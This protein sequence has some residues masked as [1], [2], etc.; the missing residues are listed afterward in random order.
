MHEIACWPQQRDSAGERKWATRGSEDGSKHSSRAQFLQGCLASEQKRCAGLREQ[1][2]L[3][4]AQERAAQETEEQLLAALEELQKQRQ[5]LLEALRKGEGAASRSEAKQRELTAEI[6]LASQDSS[7]ISTQRSPILRVLSANGTGS[8]P[9]AVSRRELRVGRPV[10][11]PNR[12]NDCFWL[13]ALQCLRHAPGFT[14]AMS[15]ALPRSDDDTPENLVE[16]VALLFAK[17]EAA[18]QEGKLQEDC[19][20]L[21][22]LRSELMK[23]LP[24]SDSGKTLIQ[25][26]SGSQRQQDTHEFLQQ[27]LDHLG[28]AFP[29]SKEASPRGAPD[30]ERLE[31]VEKEL[32]EAARTSFSQNHLPNA[33]K[34]RAQENAQNLSYEYCMIQWSASTTRM[35]SRIIGNLFEGQHLAYI[36]CKHCGRFCPSSAEPFIM[37]EVKM[38]DVAD[39]SSWLSNF[40]GLFSSAGAAKPQKLSLVDLLQQQTASPAPEGYICPSSR[41]KQVDGSTRK[42]NFFR[43]PAILVVHVNRALADGSRCEAVL[44]FSKKLDLG[45]QGMVVHFGQALDRQL[46]PCSQQ[47][48]LFAVVF[49]RGPT[50]RSGHYFAYVCVEENWVCVDD[51][52]VVQPVGES[53]A[54]PWALEASEPPQ[55]G[56]RVAM[57]FYRRR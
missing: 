5:S 49:H 28:C 21:R 8:Q 54:T 25:T 53:K 56:A 35:R 42:S 13:A 12:S 1:I 36:S 40:G 39:D 23:A 10:G 2:K 50:A 31:Q 11:L 3:A 55:G 19:P 18:E 6:M 48:S 46:E 44:D 38:A 33:Y 4:R 37:E 27:L 41:C 32:M 45:K 57:L 22:D 17:M 29:D 24:A 9:V 30:A 47:Y 16:A 14:A 15:L 26:S 20:V 34:A 51:S 43:L 7:S 52:R